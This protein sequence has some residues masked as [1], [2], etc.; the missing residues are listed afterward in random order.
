VLVFA[1]HNIGV[2]CYIFWQMKSTLGLNIKVRNGSPGM[3]VR[4]ELAWDSLRVVR[5]QIT[6]SWV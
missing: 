3:T 4:V 5:N 1:K 6:D 2:W